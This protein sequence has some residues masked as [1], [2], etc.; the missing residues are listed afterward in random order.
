M[1]IGF[2]FG[3]RE[4]VRVG[5]LEFIGID[6]HLGS[7]GSASIKDVI[8]YGYWMR[9]KNNWPRNPILLDRL[10]HEN[11]PEYAKYL[12]HYLEIFGQCDALILS[13]GYDCPPVSFLTKHFSHVKK[14][15]VFVDDP[16]STASFSLP[17]CS[18]A[19]GAIY[20]SHRYTADYLFSD[21]LA[22]LGFCPAHQ[23]FMPLCL[24]NTKTSIIPV[25]TDASRSGCCYIGTYDGEKAFRLKDLKSRLGSNLSIGGK[26]PL[27]G[28]GSILRLLS[29]EFSYFGRVKYM[30]NVEKDRLYSESLVGFNLHL[31]HTPQIESGNIRTYE[32]PWKGLCLVTD[33]PTIPRELYP[34]V[35]DEEC[36][37]YDD[38]TEAG[39]YIHYLLNN[40]EIALKVAANGQSRAMRDYSR[41]RVLTR[42]G[43]WILNDVN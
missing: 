1:K 9:S 13:G 36:F 32:V 10:Y 17:F 25:K 28:F 16:H 26:Y 5:Q 37:Y 4:A 18:I 7:L 8:N 6:Q 12:D 23:H 22:D 20:I 40:P 41:D 42:L 43:S 3:Q 2:S 11:D 14:Y 19:S 33:R 34:Y 39:D 21:W 29:G 27:W 24:G 35:E 15:V 31:S 38:I 30:S